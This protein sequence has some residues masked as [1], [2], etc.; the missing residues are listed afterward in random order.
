MVPMVRVACGVLHVC[1]D[2]LCTSY[3]SG[4]VYVW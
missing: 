3:G 2:L 1:G 4:F